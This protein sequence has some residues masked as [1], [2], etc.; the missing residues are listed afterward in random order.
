MPL[1]GY[2]GA[3]YQNGNLWPNASRK[4][5]PISYWQLGRGRLTLL[6]PPCKRCNLRDSELSLAGHKVTVSEG[7]R[8]VAQ[9]AAASPPIPRRRSQLGSHGAQQLFRFQIFHRL[10]ILRRFFVVVVGGVFFPLTFGT[11]GEKER[12]RCRSNSET[13][14]PI[15]Q[16]LHSSTCTRWRIK[17]LENIHKVA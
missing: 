11:V 4:M 10:R 7:H 8:A 14:Q 5:Q 15:Q 2:R 3:V 1:G 9:P 16:L 12:K 17:R 13:V 6:K